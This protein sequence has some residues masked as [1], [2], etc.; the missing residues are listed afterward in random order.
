MFLSGWDVTHLYL[1]K[2]P[3][4]ARTDWLPFKVREEMFTYDFESDIHLV[5]YEKTWFNV[6]RFYNEN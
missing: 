2:V 6:D 4:T 1:H 5:D 3:G